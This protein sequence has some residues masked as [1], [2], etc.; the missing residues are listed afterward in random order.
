MSGE[1]CSGCGK[2]LTGADRRSDLCDDCQKAA[3]VL[4]HNVGETEDNGGE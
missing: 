3:G 4:S 2:R 1:P